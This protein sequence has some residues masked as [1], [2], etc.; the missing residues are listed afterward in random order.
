VAPGSS[1]YGASILS[2]SSYSTRSGTS[3]AAPHV[4]GG[5]ALVMGKEVGG[6]GTD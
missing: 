4:T 2:N 5:I 6:A 1:I 3:Q